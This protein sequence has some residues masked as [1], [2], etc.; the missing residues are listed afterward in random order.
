MNKQPVSQPVDPLDFGPQYARDNPFTKRMRFHQSWYRVNKLKVPYGIGPKQKS[1]TYYGNMLT[2]ADG[3]RGLN[4]LSGHTFEIAKRRLAVSKGTIDRFRL[5]CN[6][7]SSQ[8]M[9]FNLFAPLV[10]DL[11]LAARLMGVLLPDEI[12]PVNKVELEY[13]PEPARNYLNDRTAFDAFVAYTRRDGLPGFVGIE[14]KLTE[15]FSPKVY[16]SRLYHCWTN[17]R[18]SP[19]P[20]ENLPRL[21]S[22]NVNQLWRDHLLAVAM[23]LAPGSEYA[24]GR[25][26]LVVFVN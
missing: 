4:F 17:D 9:C 13:A 1:K 24:S 25:F 6:M 23:R 7:L 14:T 16:S 12:G 15:S 21:Q 11:E 5:C 20:A 26:M 19:W 2:L 8:P 10:D 18:Q 3:E 22:K